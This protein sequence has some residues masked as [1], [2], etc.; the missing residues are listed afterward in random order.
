MK[1]EAKDK[2]KNS[3]NTD[4]KKSL[5]RTFNIQ[6]AKKDD[7]YY[8]QLKDIEEEL[9]HYSKR[10][11]KN[12][13][14]YLNCDDDNSQFFKYFYD[15]FNYFGLKKIIATSYKENKKSQAIIVTKDDE[16]DVL[17]RE[18]RNLKGDGDFRS[19]ESINF[20]KES[21]IVVT[22]PPFS[23][24]RDFLSQLIRYDKKFIIMGNV[25]SSI[26]KESFKLIF[27]NKMWIGKSPI[28]HTF[29][30]KDNSKIQLGMTCWFTNVG[31]P[32]IREKLELKHSYKNNKL[33]YHKLDNYDAILV[34]RLVNI[35]KD[36]NG[37]MAVP[38]TILYKLNTDQF[39]LIGECSS[40]K[41]TFDKYNNKTRYHRIV[42]GIKSESTITNRNPI[43]QCDRSEA[44]LQS[45]IEEK[46]FKRL[47]S[48]VLIKKVNTNDN[49]K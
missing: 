11:F 30:R 47:Y 48:K 5:N 4:S 17:I 43:I 33:H 16:S 23:L 34:D 46:Y 42:N 31:K 26:Y 49:N 25:G 35:P 3:A 14:I 8:T 15:R 12:K 28:G 19:K 36:Y 21:D 38:L 6:K 41:E 37:L 7:E 24:F 20:L 9:K 32:H 45:T 1:L 29:I 10:H 44:T 2:Y 40:S 39:E 27:E 13:T 22:N 18:S